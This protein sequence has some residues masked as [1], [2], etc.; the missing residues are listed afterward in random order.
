MVPEQVRRTVEEAD[1]TL[2]EDVADWFDAGVER[3]RLILLGPVNAE[4]FGEAK[5]VILKRRPYFVEILAYLALH[6]KGATAS[7]V[8]DAF[9]I[10][11]S[12]ARTDV[13][14]LRDWLGTN[15]RTKGPY[16]PAANESPAYFE[17]GVKTYQ[18]QDV[19]VDVDLFRR[20]RAR[21]E[22]RGAAGI[23]DLKTAMSLVQGL[24]F[25]LLRE[26]GWSWL[27]DTE[28]VHETVGCAIVDTAHI[29][30]L[31]ALA[32]GDLDSAREVAETACE[33]APYDDI[34]RLDLVKVA[35]AEGHDEAADK[36]LDDDVF[37]RTDDYLPPIDL[38]GQDRE[39]R[40]RTT[41]GPD[42]LVHGSDSKK[43]V[44][45]MSRRRRVP[46]GLTRQRPSRRR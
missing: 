19:L 8:A 34:C 31:D 30:V 38:P 9:G 13:S 4:A 3:P 28:R 18:L 45:P 43:A 14:S 41:A 22:A 37:N 25:S 27:L 29:L 23:D 44:T 20:L 21:G 1:P 32:K 46:A 7:Q 39:G 12:R 11:A 6:P 17:S 2:D 16:L 42:V 35:A 33:A 24:P 26:K 36:M 40:Q 15:P 10:A 5:P